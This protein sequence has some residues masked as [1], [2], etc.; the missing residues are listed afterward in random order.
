MQVM[1]FEPGAIIELDDP[2]TGK[3]RL[4]L[5]SESGTEYVDYLDD[6]APATPLGIFDTLD[7][8]VVG[9]D[10]VWVRENM[11]AGDLKA[12]AFRDLTMA[13]FD[14]PAGVD[15]LTRC[16]A[17][18]HALKTGHYDLADAVAAGLQATADARARQAKI[19]ARA[20]QLVEAGVV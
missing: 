9:D 10:G 6:E 8:K 13:L 5:V 14:S 20:A 12:Y 11:A 16:R 19:S 1:S 3:R 7:P 2:L 4:A 17:A 18:Y 15:K